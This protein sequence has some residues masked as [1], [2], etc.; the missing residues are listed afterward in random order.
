MNYFIFRKVLRNVFSGEVGKLTI[1][2]SVKFLQDAVCKKSL[3]SVN[4]WPSYYK[5]KNVIIFWDTVYISNNIN[6]NVCGAFI[7]AQ[8]IVQFTG[9]SDVNQHKQL[10]T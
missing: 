8:I 2:Y 4:I 1:Y 6:Y 10:I 5:N 7:V 9:L 3:K